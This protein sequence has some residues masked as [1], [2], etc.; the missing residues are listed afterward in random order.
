MLWFGIPLLVF[1]GYWVRYSVQRAAGA[2]LRHRVLCEQITLGMTRSE[3]E[4][5]LS[6]YG[7]FRETESGTNGNEVVYW[8]YTDPQVTRDFGGT[9]FVLRF[10][11]GGFVNTYLP[12]PF[13]DNNEP[14]CP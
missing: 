9:Y 7:Q 1:V 5:I 10:D 3:V 14:V 4:Q 6:A 12:V 13:S 2:E 8:S 11:N